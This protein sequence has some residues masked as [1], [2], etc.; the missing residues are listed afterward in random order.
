[1]NLQKVIGK[2]YENIESEISSS[3]LF[4][5]NKKVEKIIAAYNKFKSDNYQKKGFLPF[6]IREK[7]DE[8]IKVLYPFNYAPEDITTVCTYL[9]ITEPNEELAIGT[10]LSKLINYHYEKNQYKGEYILILHH[11][12]PP[13]IYVGLENAGATIIVKGDV[14]DSCGREMT[15]GILR[16][17]GNAKNN[18]GDAMKGGELI[19]ENAGNCAGLLMSGGTLRIQENAGENIGDLMKNGTIFIQGNYTSVSI[20]E[21]I[22]AGEIYHQGRKIFQRKFL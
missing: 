11:F 13:L 18:C 2:E 8:Q 17:L 19:V 4:E 21:T 5:K 7:I 10:F 14:G 16:I 3:L 12:D 9:E 6:S 1:M 22:H 20:S 15:N